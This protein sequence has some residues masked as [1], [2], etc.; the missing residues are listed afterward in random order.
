[1]AFLRL[2]RGVHDGR[3]DQTLVLREG[4]LVANGEGRRELEV[5]TDGPLDEQADEPHS[6]G[7]RGGLSK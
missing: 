3:K 5:A 2:A 1:M 4:Q 6:A 7:D